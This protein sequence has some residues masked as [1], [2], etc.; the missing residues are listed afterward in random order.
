MENPP[1]VCTPGMNMS[2]LRSSTF[3]NIKGKVRGKDTQIML[4]IERKIIKKKNR[5]C[6]NFVH[7]WEPFDYNTTKMKCFGL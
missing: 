2:N 4:N 1:M 6:E 7:N 3:F 5:N